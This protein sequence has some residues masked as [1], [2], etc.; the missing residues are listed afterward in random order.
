MKIEAGELKTAL[1]FAVSISKEAGELTLNLFRQPFAVETK[2]DGSFVTEVDR[3]AEAHL[4]RRIAETFGDDGILGEE[5]GELAGS[6]GRRWIIDPIDG[7]YSF[8]HGVPIFGV[9][10]ALEIAEQAVVG[11]VNL[12]ALGD[13]VYAARGLGW[14]WNGERV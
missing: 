1:E 4:R 11:V 6:S 8:V 2:R 3:A 7:T 5:D 12:P 13:L 9:L 10:V 14:F